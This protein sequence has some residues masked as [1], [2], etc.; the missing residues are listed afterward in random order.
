M[1][2]SKFTSNLLVVVSSV[3]FL[4]SKAEAQFLPI[5]KTKSKNCLLTITSQHRSGGNEVAS[6]SFDA[7]NKKACESIRKSFSQN[8]APK[9][10]VS[11]SVDMKWSGK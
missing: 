5:E 8:F 11:V 4:S 9:R 1:R 2:Y 10:M 3:I 6:R 7:K